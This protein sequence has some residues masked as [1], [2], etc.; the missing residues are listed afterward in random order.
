MKNPFLFEVFGTS[1]PRSLISIIVKHL[2]YFYT[3]REIF[4]L[5]NYE[6]KFR[7]LFIDDWPGMF[8]IQR[9]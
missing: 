5:Q 2:L 3:R 1:S 7:N 6:G 4:L 8:L 9:R